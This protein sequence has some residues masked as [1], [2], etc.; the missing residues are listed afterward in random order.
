[1][2]GPLELGLLAPLDLATEGG[3]L[4][5]LELGL[6][7]PLETTRDGDLLGPLELATLCREEGLLGPLELATEGDLLGPLEI[8]SVTDSSVVVLGVVLCN[9]RSTEACVFWR[10]R[11]MSYTTRY[12]ISTLPSS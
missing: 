4:G 8:R 7:G 1:M 2:L 11:C 5:P 12:T 6:L 9:D 10:S 3:L